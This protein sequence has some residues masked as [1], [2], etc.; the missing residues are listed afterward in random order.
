MSATS[1]AIAGSVDLDPARF[2]RIF[3]TGTGHTTPRVVT[4]PVPEHFMQSHSNT[5]QQSIPSDSAPPTFLRLPMVVRM[6]GLGRSTIYRLMAMNRFPC[7]VR[8]GDRAVAWR[9]SDLD[10]WSE[11]RPSTAHSAP[12]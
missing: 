11:A 12:H 7:P 5:F 8:V 9:R 1:A 6:T 10:R 4:Q 3:I 2:E